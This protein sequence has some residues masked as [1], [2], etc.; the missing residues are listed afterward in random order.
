MANIPV[1][2]EMLAAGRNAGA[3]WS[4]AGLSFADE[5]WTAVYQAMRAAEPTGHS[6]PV[7]ILVGTS[8]Q[9]EAAVDRFKGRLEHYLRHPGP[10][11]Y[12][13]CA[14]QKFSTPGTMSWPPPG[15]S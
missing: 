7:T 8:N 1:T 2:P 14:D 10:R 4:R 3:T 9:I 6:E 12:P 15:A 11:I 13:F 5:W